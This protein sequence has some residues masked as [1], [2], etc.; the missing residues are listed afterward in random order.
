M[1]TWRSGWRGWG[2]EAAAC[3]RRAMNRLSKWCLPL[4]MLLLT[5]GCSSGNASRRGGTSLEARAEQL[6]ESN[7]ALQE[8]IRQKEAQ[9][10]QAFASVTQAENTAGLQGLGCAVVM[11][12]KA[13]PKGV[14]RSGEIH[15]RL[16]LTHQSYRMTATFSSPRATGGWRVAQGNCTVVSP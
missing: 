13:A 1:R 3:Y 6:E 15:A 11:P 14:P 5:S 9:I 16:G 2:R 4:A 8:Q 10:E 7:R 12:A